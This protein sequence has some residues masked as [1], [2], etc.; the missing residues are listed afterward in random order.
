[1]P[2][3]EN[4]ERDVELLERRLVDDGKLEALALFQAGVK[5]RLARKVLATEEKDGWK[6]TR[7]STA[8]SASKKTA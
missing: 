7:L 6:L 5:E 8:P 3:T 2:K 1:M 4:P